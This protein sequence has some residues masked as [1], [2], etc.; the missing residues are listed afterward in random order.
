M[1]TIK[2]W[3]NT[4]K[5]RVAWVDPSGVRHRPIL[6]KKEAQDLYDQVCAKKVFDKSGLAP[7]FGAR[8]KHLKSMTFEELAKP[9]KEYL[10]KT[11]ASN[12]VSYIE[13]LIE[14]WGKWRLNQITP[15]QVKPWILGLIQQPEDKRDA[16]STIK[17]LVAYFKT[18]FNYGVEMEIIP[19]NP[20]LRLENDRI[21]KEFRRVN[22]RTKTF[23]AD[24]FWSMVKDFPQWIRRPC[25]CAWSTGMRQGEIISLKWH[26]VNLVDRLIIIQPSGDK[27]ADI[28][29]IG[30]EQDLYD[31]LI[32]I[33]TERGG[34]KADDYVFLSSLNKMI[35]R[36]YF[37]KVFR[38]SADDADF[39]GFVFHDLRH[40]YTV[41]KRREGFDK[42]V[43]KAQ[44]GHHTDHMFSWYDKVDRS[45]IQEMA[46]YTQANGETLKG[47][48]V[49]LVQKAR[50]NSI[51]L[52]A[53]QSLIGRLWR[54]SV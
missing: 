27:E 21:K 15:G 47:D 45:E 53:V 30:I 24:Q 48:I 7:E 17:K 42:S 54:V 33:Q 1:A 31:V 18:V 5:Y 22:K 6:P 34:C 4:G 16:I 46:G 14:K 20:I 8:A 3:K 52:G 36:E 44:T 26:N 12:N 38:K 13:R 9:Y 2:P 43:I 28:K 25:I 51:P 32:E 41:R 29:T 11:R 37:E 10:L 39:S 40:S 23:S 50:E 35:I 19:S 49:A